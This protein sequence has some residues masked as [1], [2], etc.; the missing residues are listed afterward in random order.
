MLLV[1]CHLKNAQIKRVLDHE[2][3]AV[4]CNSFDK[5][6]SANTSTPDDFAFP[7]TSAGSTDCSEALFDSASAADCSG[8]LFESTSTC[9][10]FL[11]A[12]NGILNFFGLGACI[13][14]KHIEKIE[15]YSFCLK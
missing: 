3:T 6:S 10:W 1:Y 7:Y 11:L 13:Q 9:V 2:I 4:F 12:Q 14:Q 5:L 15:N 8:A